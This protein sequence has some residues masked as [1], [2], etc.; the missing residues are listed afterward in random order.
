MWAYCSLLCFFL[1][2]NMPVI[3]AKKGAPKPRGQKEPRFDKAIMEPGEYEVTKASTF[4]I[5]MHLRRRSKTDPWW[6]IVGTKKEAEV[7]EEVTFRMWTYDEMVELR[8]M[9]TKYDT[10]RRVHMIDHDILNRLKMQRF[11]KSWTFD[12]SN[13][14]LELQHV[15]GVMTDEAWNKVTKLQ[16]NLLKYIIDQMNECYEFNG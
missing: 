5:T 13:P 9:A 7:T 8:K 15:N 2:G 1:G 14:R 6:I 10:V 12:K 3:E 16:T 11:L 4:T